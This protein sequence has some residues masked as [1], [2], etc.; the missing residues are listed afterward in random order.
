MT[1]IWV[2]ALVPAV[3]VLALLHALPLWP[4]PACL[5]GVRVTPEIRTGPE[6]V[7]LL[8]RYQLRLL[9]FTAAAILPVILLLRV[10]W[11]LTAMVVAWLASVALA[12]HCH[13]AA[14]RFALP[15]PSIREAS[16]TRDAGG[17]ARRL[18]WFAPPFALLG[19]TAIYLA[20]NWNSIPETFP[21]PLLGQPNA[22]SH[23][24]I[25]DVFGGLILGACLLGC[26]SLCA[27]RYRRAAARSVMLAAFVGPS[28]LIAI[29][30]SLAA[31]F[32]LLHPPAW[33][34][35]LLVGGFLPVFVILI[36]G[37]RAPL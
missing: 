23:R 36:A 7:R 18:A 21:I 27:T 16:V 22:W 33:L 28:Y 24:N 19:V 9:P 31:L 29:L 10:P 15:P 32:P 6:G 12:I 1:A 4:S 11:V 30:V 8:R 17:L 13:R 34:F 25:N 35:L 26:G 20:A 14:R 5:F 37:A 2:V 3:W